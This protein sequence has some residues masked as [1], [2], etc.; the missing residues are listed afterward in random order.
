MSTNSSYIEIP[1]IEASHILCDLFKFKSIHIIQ[2]KYSSDSINFSKRT[3]FLEPIPRRQIQ[4]EK[5]I[6]SGADTGFWDNSSDY[7]SCFSV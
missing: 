4:W 2:I 5:M 7:Y 1:L 6:N 3:I